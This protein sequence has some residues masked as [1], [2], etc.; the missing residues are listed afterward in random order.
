VNLATDAQGLAS[1]VW[2]LDG[3]NLHQSCRATLLDATQ[4]PV[5]NQVVRFSASL[6]RASE[7]AYDPRAC[8]DLLAAGVR[9]VQQAIDALCGRAGGGCCCVVVEPG[10]ELHRVIDELLEQ[11]ERAICLCLLVGEHVLADGSPFENREPQ[12]DLHLSIVGCGPG[13]RLQLREPLLLGGWAS[14]HLGDID[15]TCADR[16]FIAPRAQDV[17][18]ERCRISGPASNAGLLQVYEAQRFRL[19]ACTL[20]AIA[21]PQLTGPAEFC[22]NVF[23]DPELWR[24]VDLAEFQARTRREAN[25]FVR[26]NDLSQIAARLTGLLAERR[27]SFTFAEA[28]AFNRFIQLIAGERP[29]PFSVIDV[30]D[31]IRIAALREQRGAALEIGPLLLEDIRRVAATRDVSIWLE[32]N[33]IA[34]SV[35]FYGAGDPNFSIPTNVL[36]TLRNRLREGASPLVGEAGVVQVRG[37]RLTNLLLGRG[38]ADA[39]RRLGTGQTSRVPV[40]AV[41]ES[42]LLDGNVVAGEN[43]MLLARHLSLNANDFTGSA[44]RPTAAGAPL[45]GAVIGDTALYVGNHGRNNLKPAVVFDATRA[46][47]R[48]ANL[49][50]VIQP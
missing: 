10:R 32:N 15:I 30:L 11:G 45:I 38:I 20:Q 29:T 40:N 48:V 43:S 1:C 12:R 14:F 19:A 46:S 5:D 3:A 21:Q 33:D 34:G 22:A 28:A 35:S 7:V 27:N 18:V 24:V 37:N 17:V 6:L 41:F 42:F 47:D 44:T 8:P 2:Q 25:I 23:E 13:T 31:E 16:A 49:E 50:L 36:N 4:T 9:T 39:V 26:R